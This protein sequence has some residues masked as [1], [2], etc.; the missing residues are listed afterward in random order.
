M[1]ENETKRITELAFIQIKYSVWSFWIVFSSFTRRTHTL[2]NSISIFVQANRCCA[3]IPNANRTLITL[4]FISGT[5]TSKLST[6][7]C[8]ISRINCWLAANI[9]CSREWW[10]QFT[11]NRCRLSLR[12][13]ALAIFAF[14]SAASSYHRELTNIFV[15][16]PEMNEKWNHRF[17][18][19][20]VMK[21]K[22]CASAETRRRGTHENTAH[23][24]SEHNTQLTIYNK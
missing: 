17:D 24:K 18:H 6:H 22:A 3:Y 16:N 10:I 9:L 5:D 13:F 11:R 19:V 23:V 14:R 7:K 2:R 1:N 4:A 15:I 20:L 8:D 21:R 12:R